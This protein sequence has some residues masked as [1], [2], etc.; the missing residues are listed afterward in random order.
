[1][2]ASTS[3]ED[4]AAIGSP[5]ARPDWTR[6]TPIVRTIVL[7]IQTQTCNEAKT[8]TVDRWVQ[9]VIDA[10][11]EERHPAQQIKVGMGWQC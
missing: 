9:M 2:S 1:M 4:T 3:S 10:E 8:A 11:K 6:A 5:I 7:T